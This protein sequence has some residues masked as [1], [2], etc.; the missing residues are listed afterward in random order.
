MVRLG[1]RV[2]GR[3]S[4]PERSVCG[5]RGYSLDGRGRC[6]RRAP[7]APYAQTQLNEGDNIELL[8]PMQGG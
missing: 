4:M 2:E 6:F 7:A 3:R 8:A 1:L 5:R